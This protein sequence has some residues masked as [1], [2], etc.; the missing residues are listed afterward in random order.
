MQLRPCRTAELPEPEHVAQRV[1]LL[2][3]GRPARRIAGERLRIDVELVGDERERRVRDQLPRPEQP[4]GITERAEL[5]GE[6]EPVGVTSSFV[7]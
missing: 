3:A 6:A 4:A 2:V 1:E 7:R 5:D